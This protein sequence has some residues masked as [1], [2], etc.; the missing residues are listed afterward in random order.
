MITNTY[1]GKTTEQRF[2][3]K[4]E[5]TDSCWEFNGTKSQKYGQISVSGKMIPAH[6]FSYMI[7]KGEIP[8]GLEVCHKCDNCKCVNPKHLFLG[9]HKENM[10][11]GR[12]KGNWARE[13]NGR[14]KHNWKEIE[15]IK[16]MYKTGKYSQR[17]LGEIFGVSHTNIYAI[18]KG[19]LWDSCIVALTTTQK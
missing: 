9:T 10:E 2:W 18:M 7:H 5:K 19:K 6:R 17:K 11:D 15:L 12:S 1:L 13:R 4:V 14:A 3:D 8:Q 16:K